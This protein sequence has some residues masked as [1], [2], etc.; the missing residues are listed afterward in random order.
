MYDENN[1]VDINWRFY[2]S[3]QYM[4]CYSAS[5]RDNCE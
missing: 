5:G 4:A 3:S 1:N 2:V